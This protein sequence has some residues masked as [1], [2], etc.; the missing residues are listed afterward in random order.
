MTTFVSEHPK[1]G[2]EET[3]ND[4]VEEPQDSTCWSKWD[5]LWSD[6]TVEQVKCGGQTSHIASHISQSSQARTFVAV[7]WN[8]ISDIVDG[9][10]WY[11]KLISISVDQ[12][13][14]L[15]GFLCISCIV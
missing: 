5:V 14:E 1:T 2:T 15:R 11:L 3:L 7:F 6:K 12:L 4:G 8:R 13:A 9:I 10:V